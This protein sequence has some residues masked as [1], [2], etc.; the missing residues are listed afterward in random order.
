MFVTIWMCTHEWS[1][2][3]IR[4]TAFTFETCH[5]RLE[6]LVL[7]HPLDQRAQLAVAAHRHVD[8]HAL[9]R[10]GRRE[11]RLVLGLLR[12]RLVD[13]V[14]GLLVDRHGRSLTH[15]HRC[16]GAAST[17]STSSSRTTSGGTG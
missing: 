16:R 12:D 9:D 6:L 7:V 15:V 17:R 3:S 8:L 11:P 5:Q 1:L 10:L 13:P 2:I 4:A 14:S